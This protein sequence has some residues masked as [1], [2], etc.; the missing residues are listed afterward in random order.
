MARSYQDAKK[1]AENISYNYI[2][3]E[4]ELLLN[5]FIEIPSDD[6]YQ[7]QEIELTLLIPNGKSI[8]LDE[9]LKYFIHDIRNVTRTRDY[10]MVEHTWQMKADGLTCLDCN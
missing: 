1:Y 5:Q 9:T 4:G 6:P 3:N 10:K 2:L 8:Y 7:H